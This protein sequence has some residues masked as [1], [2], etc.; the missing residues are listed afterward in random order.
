MVGAILGPAGGP[1]GGEEEYVKERNERAEQDRLTW[2]LE[3]ELHN[4]ATEQD[5]AELAALRERRRERC[6]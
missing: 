2:L 4:A 5:K 3:L 6:P 1:L